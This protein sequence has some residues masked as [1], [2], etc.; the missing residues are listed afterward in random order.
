MRRVFILAALA[1][2]ALSGAAAAQSPNCTQSVQIPASGAGTLKLVADPPGSSRVYVCGYVLNAGT[3]AGAGQLQGGTG[4]SCA[5]GNALLTGVLSL[6]INGVLVDPSPSFRG[7]QT[8]PGA[9]LCL[10]ITGTG[11]VSGVLYYTQQ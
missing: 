3:A 8:A 6:G 1:W 5:G 7:M 9:G 4:G 10:V 11:P 2:C